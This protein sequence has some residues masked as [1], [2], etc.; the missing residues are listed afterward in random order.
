MSKLK[1]FIC[2]ASVIFG[3]FIN[4]AFASFPQYKTA[5][6]VLDYNTGKVLYQQNP[7]ILVHPASLTKMMTLYLAFQKLQANQLSLQQR[8][9]VSSYAASKAPS[10]LGLKA[11]QYVSVEDLILG[12][13]TRSA[14]DAATV[15]AEGI[16]GSEPKFVAMMNQQASALGMAHTIFYNASGLP[17]P[18]QYT[19]AADMALLGKAL[20]QKQPRY[21][22]YFSTRSF[23]FGGQVI[24]S[25]N[26]LLDWYQGADGIKT[27]FVNASGFNLVASAMR[28]NRRLIG[29]IFGASS[30]KARDR[31]MASLLDRCFNMSA[32]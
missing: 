25:H 21:Y 19:T 12:V 11:G 3:F 31:H 29:V 32:S 18:K 14:N 30:A 13:V 15:L 17:N 27:G 2:I 22:G 23:M 6:L 24:R 28:N 26:H 7:N 4:S 1:T 9:R 10:K 8:F 20:L 16:G 5:S